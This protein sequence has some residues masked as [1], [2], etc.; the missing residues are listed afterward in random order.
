MSKELIA[1]I[2]ELN[3]RERTLRNDL[4]TTQSTIKSNLEQLAGEVLDV[5]LGKTVIV[6]NLGKRYVAAKWE[7]INLDGLKQITNGL[8]LAW[9]RPNLDGHP[10]KKNGDVSKAVRY[11]S[12]WKKE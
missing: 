1:K 3:S 6:D 4:R 5:E 2:E 8:T 7:N 11:V 12:G 10:F 9:G